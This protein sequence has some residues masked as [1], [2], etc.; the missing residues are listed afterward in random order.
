[1]A[2]VNL[3]QIFPSPIWDIKNEVSDE[4]I[5][6]LKQFAYSAIKQY[7]NVDISSK[8]GG[9]QSSV[10]LQVQHPVLMKIIGDNIQQ[11]IKEFEPVTK[12]R[13]QNY[14]VNVNPPGSYM[15]AHVHPRSVLACTL[16]VQTP[17]NSGRITFINPNLA[18]R[19]A[20]YS[21]KE[22][23]YNY[24]SY[25]YQPIPGMLIC[26]PSWLDHGVEENLSKDDRISISFNLI[27]D[28]I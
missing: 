26:F 2:G 21:F 19:Q 11:I 27:A 6:E 20:F 5:K 4:D 1:M 25:S 14:W 13:L 22:T 17:P 16:Y 3:T 28:D 8:R 7:P 23:E 24:K 9:G 12:L 18:A 15:I 10:P